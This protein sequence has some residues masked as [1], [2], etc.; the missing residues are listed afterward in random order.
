MWTLQC[1]RP[2]WVPIN[3]STLLC[4]P[5]LHDVFK[6]ECFRIL[7]RQAM[8]VF[9]WLIFLLFDIFLHTDRNSCHNS[10]HLLTQ[11]HSPNTNQVRFWSLELKNYHV[12]QCN[13]VSCLAAQ[14]L[15]STHTTSIG[16]WLSTCRLTWVAFSGVGSSLLD[17]I[18]SE[19]ALNCTHVWKLWSKLESIYRHAFSV[20]S[21]G[22]F[23]GAKE[24]GSFN[25]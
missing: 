7:R 19:V 22:A 12:R 8:S 10:C 20:Y 24:A 15:V 18:L 6:I 17:V 23:I 3:L 21:E 1:L 2:Q 5:V 13:H 16:L 4:L 14:W 9:C 25:F 11:I